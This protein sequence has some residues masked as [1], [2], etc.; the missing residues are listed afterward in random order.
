VATG[1]LVGLSGGLAA[2][3]LVKAADVESAYARVTDATDGF[4][5]ALASD[6]APDALKRELEDAPGVETA[7][8][9][10]GYA[11][12]AFTEGGEALGP[13]PSQ[14]C[15][16]GTGEVAAIAHSA[17]WR[18]RA[19]QML[20]SEG[21]FPRPDR[22][23]VVLPVVAAERLG[24]TVG[25]AVAIGGDCADGPEEFADPVELV[26]TG[27]GVG[28]FDGPGVGANSVVE[29]LLVSTSVVATLERL[30][31]ARQTFV[32][33][34]LDRGA[35]VSRLTLPDGAVPALDMQAT[36]DAIALDL[37][38]DATALRLAAL[39]IA[40]SAMVV[41]GPTLSR[42]V[43]SGSRDRP[44][45]S[46]LG[47]DRRQLAA[48]G[49]LRG[50]PVAAA[51]TLA[52]GAAM[53]AVSSSL[54]VGAAELFA[55]AVSFAPG[56]ERAVAGSAVVGAVCLL[57][58][59]GVSW[60]IARS[61]PSSGAARAPGLADRV[62]TTLRLRPAEAAGVRFALE[63]GSLHDPAPVR[64]G[65][66]TMAV[67]VGAVAGVITFSSSLD[68]L[69]D[70]PA[71]YGVNW[72][73]FV[74]SEDAAS[75]G[76][77]LD[78]REEVERVAVGTFFPPQGATLGDTREEVWL[79]SFEAGPERAEPS[80]ISG[81]APQADHEVMIAPDLRG[82]LAASVGDVIDL[83]LPSAPAQL[84]EQLGRSWEGPAER[85]TELEIVGIGVLPVGDGRIGTGAS[86]T[87]A[88]LQAA[89]GP[90]TS[91]ELL[92]L[93]AATPG[94]VIGEV[95]RRDL[96]PAVTDE[97]L[98][99][100]SGPEILDVFVEPLRPQIVVFDAHGPARAA[101]VAIAASQGSLSREDFS[102]PPTPEGVIN[103]DLSDAGRI[104]D[105]F[106]GLMAVVAVGLVVLLVATGGRQRHHDLALLRALGFERTQVRRALIAQA[107]VTVLV[108]CVLVPAGVAIGRVAW[109]A[110]A[111]NLGVVPEP[112]VSL[113]E[114]GAAPTSLLVIAVIT[115][116]TAARRQRGGTVAEQLKPLE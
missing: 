98:A 102:E 57:L 77:A 19:P 84:A 103:L 83:H 4:D 58:I 91:P 93:I 107:A 54:P 6:R 73:A 42:V 28:V 7:A 33:G 43:R 96:D 27:I 26:V 79:M 113:I 89:L 52:A 44:I 100:L 99:E 48:V 20:L 45:L 88:G 17:G 81:R 114:L 15:T 115:A 5:V 111:T 70:T 75:L 1:L 76:D 11:V 53:V 85:V 9:L 34:W 60:L 87:F 18:G 101:A 65:L 66:T 112:S 95:V 37:Q 25:D 68:H 40:V 105:A 29:T 62:A 67:A 116:V 59:T 90:A 12:A 13:D 14:P 94:G 104:P 106:S 23:E 41:L 71:L 2:A 97:M 72:D 108:A 46:G 64:S 24:L 86:M 38:P 51:A 110:Y 49:V 16:T 22:A 36:R 109:M 63:P 35:R 32:L 69:R 74:I 47:I 31:T 56:W 21:R 78:R 8:M 50:V 82:A 39:V 30:D 3:S 92:E 55:G 10:H 80:I 61:V